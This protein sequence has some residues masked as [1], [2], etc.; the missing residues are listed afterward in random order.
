[1][2]QPQPSGLQALKQ[3]LQPSL[4]RARGWARAIFRLISDGGIRADLI[5]LY[6]VVCRDPFGCRNSPLEQSKYREMLSILPAT[7]VDSLLEVGCGEGIFTRML[8]PHA[9]RLLSIDSSARAL[10]RARRHLANFTQVQFQQL[11]IEEEDPKGQ[12]DLIVVS[13]IL[14]YLG[15]KEQIS[16][17]AQRML[18]WLKPDGQLLLCHMRSQT[19]EATGFPAPRWTPHHAGAFT[20]HG[21]FDEIP[22]LKCLL[23]LNRELYRISLYHKAIREPAVGQSNP[24]TI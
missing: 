3:R 7:P 13:E 14:Y 20:V 23:D 6:Y 19:D 18:D 22:Q 17:V 16:K 1:M 11:N 9:G 10:Q 5:D 24:A 21:V 4:R 2:Q 12:F 15:P 8:L